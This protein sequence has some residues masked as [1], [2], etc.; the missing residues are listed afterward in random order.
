MKKIVVLC[1]SIFALSSFAQIK[2]VKKSSSGTPTLYISTTTNAKSAKEIG[3]LL[4]FYNWFEVTKNANADY[5]LRVL[6]MTKTSASM[7]IQPRGGKGVVIRKNSQ[8]GLLIRKSADAIINAVFRVPGICASQI[9]FVSERAKKKE[10]YVG[11]ADSLSRSKK[12]TNNRC[13]SVEP[14]WSP[15][16]KK[17]VYTLCEPNKTNIVLVDMLKKSHRRISTFR[18][19]N[20]GASF[21]KDGKQLALT[22][23]KDGR[24][25]LYKMNLRNMKVTR[26]TNNRA[27][28]SSP[29]WNPA[30]NTILAVANF[31]RI[32]KLYLFDANSGKA[33]PLSNNFAE[34]VSPDWSAVSNK[35]CFSLKR[36]RDYHIAVVD[37]NNLRAGV[38]LLTKT[39]GS[40][41]EPS[42]APDGRNLVCVRRYAGK[43]TL[44]LIDS[45][46]GKAKPMHKSGLVDASLP[47]WSP[48][49]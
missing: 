26:V 3:S 17:L 21:S 13:L 22:L 32:P 9:A 2:V 43:S 40:W 35:I 39:A 6:S 34:A 48:L 16:G 36:G 10:I 45:K 33:R 11:I 4:N 30:G 44:Y 28:E 8:N 18:G 12:L 1:L 37:M 20:A 46:T 27:E 41:E 49:Y 7:V 19:M 23:S 42:W 15:D 38:K 24:V 14:N 31:Q 5:T 29:C 47:S 25:E